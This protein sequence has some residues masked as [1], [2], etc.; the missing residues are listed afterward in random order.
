MVFCSLFFCRFCSFN[1]LGTPEDLKS[2]IDKA[3]SYGI[4]VL[5]DLVHSHAS[6]NTADGLNEFDGTDGCYF[7]SGPKGTHAMWDR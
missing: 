4:V 6:K 7:H 3:H 2:L 1:F 5:L